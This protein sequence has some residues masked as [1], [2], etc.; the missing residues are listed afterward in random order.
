MDSEETAKLGQTAMELMQDLEADEELPEGAV[1]EE[2]GLVASVR[3]PDPD[4]G[5][6]L[7]AVHMRATS[8]NR[9]VQV[10]LFQVAA[11][12]AEETTGDEA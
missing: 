4:G 11:R 3:F 2:I 12:L 7:E 1:L 6:D 9:L 5:E 8:S 10:G